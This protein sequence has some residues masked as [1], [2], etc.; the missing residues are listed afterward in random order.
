MRRLLR[1][2]RNSSGD[3]QLDCAVRVAVVVVL[4]MVAVLLVSVF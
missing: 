2:R 4:V 3:P 1:V